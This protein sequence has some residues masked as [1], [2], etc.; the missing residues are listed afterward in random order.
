MRASNTGAARGTARPGRHWK[1][2][3]CLRIGVVVGGRIVEERLLSPGG[4]VTVG[5]DASNT[6]VVRTALR[7]FTLI[8]TRDGGGG[9]I[10]LAG[11]MGGKITR[12]KDVVTLA[13]AAGPARRGRRT[14]RLGPLDRGKIKV[15]D[16]TVL[17]Q[18]VRTP[19]TPARNRASKRFGGWRWEAVDWL[20][21]AVILLSGLVHTAGLMWVESQPPPTTVA[22]REIQDI[23][24]KMIEVP[25]PAPEP[26]AAVAESDA[27]GDGP[28]APEPVPE[29]A[30][31]P[32]DPDPGPVAQGDP[33]PDPEPIETP[34]QRRARLEAEVQ[35]GLIGAIDAYD[36]P[37]A[38]RIE[39]MLA[40]A[41][42]LDADVGRAV[43]EAGAGARARD[44]GDRFGLRGGSALDGVVGGGDLEVAGGGE[45]GAV[46]KDAVEI[47]TAVDVP[48]WTPPETDGSYD[49]PGQMKRYL[50][51]F[52][53]CYEKQIK[54]DDS[55]QGKLVLSWTLDLHGR[56]Y[57]VEVESNSTGSA[58][59][60]D[61]VVRRLSKVTLTSPGEEIDVI[62][63][64]LV[65]SRQ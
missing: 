51:R 12:G 4:K 2:G 19:P 39:D 23:F 38:R 42:S 65:F 49:I 48:P 36:R 52:K 9:Q 10:H 58:A 31:A 53:Q 46:Q 64:P 16:T 6:V 43:A 55:L 11:P 34:E 30:P 45:G 3:R 8:E 22:M 40:D 47:V 27:E 44:E 29:P 35:I 21:L 26:E 63:Y 33:N 20:F 57:G 56:P 41:G 54:E 32:P 25:T 1:T 60:A 37:G 50:G 7:K 13:E 24:I 18:F 15:G 59:L 17:F 62:G 14:A 61:C 5:S 28:E